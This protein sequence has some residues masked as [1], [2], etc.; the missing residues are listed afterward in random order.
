MRVRAAGVR[1]APG[2]GGRTRPP[3]GPPVKLERRT[4][5]VFYHIWCGAL[6]YNTE[7]ML[8]SAAPVAACACGYECV[9]ISVCVCVLLGMK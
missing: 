4:V 3:I 5:S 2:G 1:P 9:R 7:E 8:Q 6:N